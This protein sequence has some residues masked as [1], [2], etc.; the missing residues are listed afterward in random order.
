MLAEIARLQM[1]QAIAE[2]ARRNAHYVCVKGCKISNA[3]KGEFLRSGQWVPV[4]P[5]ATPGGTP[6]TGYPGTYPATY[7]ATYAATY[8]G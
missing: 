6:P 4:T 8:G 3:E 5:G 2:E 1:R 7:A